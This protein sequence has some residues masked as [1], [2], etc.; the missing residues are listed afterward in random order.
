VGIGESIRAFLYQPIGV[1]L[2]MTNPILI[3]PRHSIILVLILIFSDSCLP[4]SDPDRSFVEKSIKYALSIR[5]SLCFLK[6]VFLEAT[7]TCPYCKELCSRKKAVV[8]ND[9]SVATSD[10]ISTR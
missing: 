5:A 10:A 7:S 6:N 2:L 9:R 8:L 4:L 1:C 3:L